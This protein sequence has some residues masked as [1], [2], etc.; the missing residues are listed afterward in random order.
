MMWH[1]KNAAALATLLALVTTPSSRVAAACLG[2]RDIFV[3]AAFMSVAKDDGK[4]ANEL[5]SRLGRKGQ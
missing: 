1:K 2:R 3:I 5:I 4:T